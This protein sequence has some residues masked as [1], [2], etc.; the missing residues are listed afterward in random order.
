MIEKD[1]VQ[2]I[3]K[4][5][6]DVDVTYIAIKESIDPQEKEGT[7]EYEL[8]ISES[9]MHSQIQ[10]LDRILGDYDEIEM[11]LKDGDMRIYS[12]HSIPEERLDVPISTKLEAKE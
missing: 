11:Q 3:H 4:L 8:I 5:L 6:T 9:M 10:A 7:K 2:I 1:L 12:R